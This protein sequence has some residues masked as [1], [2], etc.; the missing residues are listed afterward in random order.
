M[1]IDRFENEQ[2]IKQPRDRLDFRDDLQPSITQ[3]ST[4]LPPAELQDREFQL[5]EQMKRMRDFSKEIADNLERAAKADKS[6]GK[7]T[8]AATAGRP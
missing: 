4:P 1:S 5:F 7:R 6:A 2:F 3:Q 8:T